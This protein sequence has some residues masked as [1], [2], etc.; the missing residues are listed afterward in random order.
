[1]MAGWPEAEGVAVALAVAL[2][3]IEAELLT[4]V[5][6]E[7]EPLAL[8]EPLRLGEVLPLAVDAAETEALALP[9]L[10]ADG[11]AEPLA[12]CAADAL[13]EALPLEL[14][15]I[16]EADTLAVRL[17]LAKTELDPDG[18]GDTLGEELLEHDT[19]CRLILSLQEQ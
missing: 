7:A 17:P 4:L 16:C 12:L 1:M 3:A 2:G 8:G 15:N 11:E 13:G 9:L 18:L 5:L 19:N 10:D 6:C 14:A